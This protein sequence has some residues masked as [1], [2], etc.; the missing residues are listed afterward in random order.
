MTKRAER[1]EVEIEEVKDSAPSSDGS[2]VALEAEA[3]V[4]GHLHDT[5]IEVQRED[6]AAVAVLLLNA[7]GA[8]HTPADGYSPAVKCLGAGVVH[9]LDERNVRVHLQFDSGQV[10]PIEMP[11]DAAMAL[12]RVL[13]KHPGEV[14]GFGPPR[15]ASARAPESAA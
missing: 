13:L 15:R 12:G 2:G 11:K 9:W 8:D 5:T 10:L 1:V 3:M 6:V 14:A 7:D 4:N